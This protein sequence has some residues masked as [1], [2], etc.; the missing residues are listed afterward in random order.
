M[1]T[2]T[3]YNAR[4]KIGSRVSVGSDGELTEAQ[5]KY[6]SK[7]LCPSAH[8]CPCSFGSCSV[9]ERGFKL[10]RVVGGW[11]ITTNANG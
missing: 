2:Y 11:R 10:E 8:T 6:H 1:R 5:I 9:Q 7:K 3:L 4:H